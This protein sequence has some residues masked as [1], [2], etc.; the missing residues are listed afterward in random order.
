MESLKFSTICVGIRRWTR[1]M[2]DTATQ[3]LVQ[4]KTVVKQPG[5]IGKVWSDQTHV[6]SIIYAMHCA[7][8]NGIGY[9]QTL[10]RENRGVQWPGSLV[11]N[12]D[13]MF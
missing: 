7:E 1:D 12:V 3:I 2:G 13:D 11:P 6:G 10:V 8:A 4:E 5:S 9:C